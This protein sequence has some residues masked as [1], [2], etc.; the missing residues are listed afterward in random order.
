MSHRVDEAAL[1]VRT[2]AMK[3]LRSS[4]VLP[5]NPGVG[6][7]P[8]ARL[9]G[10][11]CLLTASIAFGGCTVESS[12]FALVEVDGAVGPGPWDGG[13]VGPSAS[14]LPD[15]AVDAAFHDADAAVDA[16]FWDAGPHDAGVG[17]AGY[18]D[19]GDGG[20]EVWD[21]GGAAP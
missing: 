19:A 9:R 21:D 1:L 3:K 6:R 16:G 7:R 11:L 20:P 17:D 8:A 14:P 4:F 5:K 2:M 13:V 12:L 15:A 18:W 10:A